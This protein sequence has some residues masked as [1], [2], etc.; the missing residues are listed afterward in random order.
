MPNEFRI[1][2]ENESDFCKIY[3]DTELEDI[4]L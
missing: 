1:N 2:E 3:L 4:Y